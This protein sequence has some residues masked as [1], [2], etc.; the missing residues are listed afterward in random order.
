MN[1][2][3]RAKKINDKTGFPGNPAL[4]AILSVIIISSCSTAGTPAPEQ[5]PG[6][7]MQAVVQLTDV[8][9]QSDF[10]E[11][12]LNTMT[13]R[14]KLAQRFIVW[15]PKF[16]DDSGLEKLKSLE[17]G[18]YIIFP[19]NYFDVAG[20]RRLTSVLSDVPA[21]NGLGLTISPFLC[22]D[23]EGGRVA[24]FRFPEFPSLPSAFSL[25]SLNDP[26]M[27]ELSGNIAGATLANLGL[28]MNLAPV[29][30]LYSRPDSTIIGDRSFG[31]DPMAT[32][33]SVV[34]YLR[35]LSGS[36]II[37]TL[38]HFPGHGITTVDSH[39]KLPVVAA[40]ADELRQGHLKPFAAGIDAGVPV[41]MTA[42]I[43]YP[44]IDPENPATLSRVILQNLLRKDLG[45][46]GIVISDGFEMGAL[47]S[48]FEV[49]ESL[50]RAFEAG[51]D[52]ILLSSRY[53]PAAMIDMAEELVRSGRIK[54]N[55]VNESVRR[56][57]KVKDRYNLLRPTA[58]PAAG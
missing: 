24:A 50:A 11:S 9:T 17:P 22:A 28:N 12:V 30:D 55:T 31:P 18:G 46:D 5:A 54:E 45:F 40:S 13:L 34:A 2:H 56:I 38:K 26:D 43:L 44:A 53:D 7:E 16:V 48:T 29:A 14:E 35:G 21:K 32:S 33:E 57:L 8:P 23:L 15:I 58:V 49:N 37:A 19:W 52:Q 36:G 1:Q 25:G 47:S 3:R 27:V 39:G 6:R 41:V 20:V 42:H 4:A 10:V 51:V